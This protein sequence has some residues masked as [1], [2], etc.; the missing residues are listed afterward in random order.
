MGSK[1]L[2]AIA[3]RGSGEVAIAT[4]EKYKK[5]RDEFAKP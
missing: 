3:I 1:N 5:A 2:K 4:S